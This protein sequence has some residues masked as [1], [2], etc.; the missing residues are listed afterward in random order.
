MNRPIAIALLLSTTLLAGNFVAMA[1]EVNYDES[2]VP[3]FALPNPLIASDGSPVEDAENWNTK[4]RSEILELFK[5]YVYGHSP[6]RP[7]HMSF[8]VF[9][10]D[11]NALNGKA[12]RKQVTIHFSEDPDGP[13]LD[14]LMLVP[15]D[16]EGP[17]PAFLIL[18]F[19]GNHSILME[20]VNF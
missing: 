16:V 6:G 19:W 1:D 12:T 3:E 18:N 15:N 10:E 11:E 8:E 9:D 2:K 20:H 17:V 14:L 7:E 4:R 5:E 13:S